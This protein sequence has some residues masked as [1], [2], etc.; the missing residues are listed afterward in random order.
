MWLSQLKSCTVKVSLAHPVATA[1][2]RICR[3]F[4]MTIL[5]PADVCSHAQAWDSIAANECFG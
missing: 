4:E 3:M 2:A 1:T 5:S